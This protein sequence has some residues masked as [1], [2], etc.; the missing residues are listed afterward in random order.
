[1]PDKFQIEPNNG[2]LSHETLTSEIWGKTISVFLSVEIQIPIANPVFVQSD[3]F[4]ALQK[5][6]AL[7][8][9]Q[10]SKLVDSYFWGAT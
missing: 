10:N 6:T 2:T 9:H 3:W 4:Q 7:K 5:A 1:M 8:F